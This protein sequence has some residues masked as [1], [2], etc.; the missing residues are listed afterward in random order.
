[1]KSLALASKVKS[2]ALASR[3]QV[4]E[5]WPVLGS[6]TAVFFELL[7]FCGALEKFFRKRFFVEI[8]RKIFVMTFFFFFGDRLKNFCEDLFFWRALAL[9]SL[10]LGLGL[11]HSCPWPRECLSSERL[12]LA[13]DFFCVL[14]LGLSLEPCVLDSTSAY[15]SLQA[16]AVA[17]LLAKVASGRN[18]SRAVDDVKFWLLCVA[19]RCFASSLNAPLGSPNHYHVIFDPQNW[20]A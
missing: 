4:L 19:S 5:N 12:S 3:P 7:K 20:H 13:S 18:L 9:V 6:R 2:L 10:V 16:S 15:Y 8:A 14:G 17:Q 1:M 11:E